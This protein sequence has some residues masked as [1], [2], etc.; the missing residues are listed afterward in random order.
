MSDKWGS[1][2]IRR[3]LIPISLVSCEER[4]E[5]ETGI[6]RRDY[7]DTVVHREHMCADGGRE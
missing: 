4:A 1:S 2:G 5:E 6:H 3:V 7:A